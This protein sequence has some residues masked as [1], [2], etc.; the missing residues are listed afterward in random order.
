MGSRAA[1][2]ETRPGDEDGGSV[3]VYGQDVGVR[4]EVEGRSAMTSIC[5][6]EAGGGEPSNSELGAK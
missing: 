2:D 6:D 3:G 5:C 4:D 1:P